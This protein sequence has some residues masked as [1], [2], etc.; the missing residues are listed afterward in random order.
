MKI[1]MLV[2]Q[3]HCIRP[4]YKSVASVLE[5]RG[6]EV[7]FALDSH[8]TDFTYPDAAL[9]SRT[10]YFSD[11]HRVNASRRTLPKQ[12]EGLNTSLMMFPDVERMQHTNAQPKRDANWLHSLAANLAHF[13]W[14]LFGAQQFDACVYENVSNAFSYFAWEVAQRK[15]ALFIGFVP[16]RLPGRTDVLDCALARD[17]R[18]PVVY[19]ALRS[20]KRGLDTEAS[21]WVDEYLTNFEQKKPDYMTNH[22]IEASVVD[23]YLN[24]SAL[25]RFTRAMRYQ[26]TS[27]ADADFAYQ[28]HNPFFAYPA[29]FLTEAIRQKLKAPLLL[30]SYY[31]H[32]V[33]LAV[34]YFVYPIQ[35]HPESATSVDGPNFIDEWSNIEVLSLNMPHGYSLYVKD[36]KH[37]IARPQPRFLSAR[38]EASKREARLA[39]LRQQEVDAPLEGD[40]LLDEHDGLRGARH[41]SAGVFARPSVSTTFSPERFA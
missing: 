28:V 6:H 31:A 20:G 8:L 23:R 19:E 27:K 3:A 21:A 37:A 30:R 38:H 33:D 9:G 13:F 34:P 41:R 16:S 10:Y 2:N 29:Q 39:A 11:Y 5:G 15:G 18:F 14:D 35:F 22:P 24:K 12:L 17:S 36:H 32:E 25:L 1:L 40:R 26:L 7:H 4:F